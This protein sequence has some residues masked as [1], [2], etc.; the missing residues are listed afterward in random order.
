MWNKLGDP[1]CRLFRRLAV[2]TMMAMIVV[3]MTV[4][5]IMALRFLWKKVMVEFVRDL[6]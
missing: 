4:M 5:M 2:V 6:V 1:V 3:M